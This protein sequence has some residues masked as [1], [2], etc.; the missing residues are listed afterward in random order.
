VASTRAS[1]DSERRTLE[2][3]RPGAYLAAERERIGL[4]LDRATRALLNRLSGDA[5]QLARDSDRASA[6]LRGRTTA[7]RADLTRSA[8]GLGALN[9]FATL[10]RGYAIVRQPDGRVVVDA[11]SQHAGAALEVR[12][13]HGALDVSVDGVRDSG[14]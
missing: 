8:A 3:F 14:S 10:E 11:A 6:L 13:A 5:A 1:L 2:T 4:L 9:P 7:A 12:L